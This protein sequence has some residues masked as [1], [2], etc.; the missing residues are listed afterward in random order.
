MNSDIKVDPIF[1]KVLDQDNRVEME[2]AAV[3]E[4]E[5]KNAEEGITHAQTAQE[6]DT[7]ARITQQ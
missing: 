5:S 6:D 1:L 2:L 7:H 3:P 4:L